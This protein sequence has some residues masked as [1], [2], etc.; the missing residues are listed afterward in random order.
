L[1]QHLVR[2][3]L[4]FVVLLALL[5][6]AARFYEIG[7]IH[8]LDAIFYDSKVR[9]TM[10]QGVDERVVILDIDEKS[11]GEIGR[12][13]WGRDRLAQL[14]GKLFDR[15]GIVLLGFD[16]VFAEP[17]ESSGLK[18][19]EEL[20]RKELKDNAAFRTLLQSLRPQL[21]RDRQFAEAL[22]GR[23][24]VLGY[25]LSARSDGVSSGALPPPALPAGSFAGRN[26][27]FTV[28]NSH[29]GNLVEFQN[30]AV[31][32][33]HFNPLVDFDGISR[34]VPLLAEYK[35]EYYE[36]L[37]LAMLRVLLGQPK[38]VP[39][40]PE[41]K[42]FAAKGY[43]GMEAIDLPT[44]RG[45]LRIPV[46]ENAAALIPYRGY[47]GSFRYFSVADILADRIEPSQLK[48]KI[49]LVG[50]TAPGLLDLRA[51]PVGEAYPGV[52]I[53][54]NLI[55]GMLDGTI[56]HKPSYVLGAEVILLLL[57]GL[58]M[59]F[60]LPL[61][62]PLRASLA[63]LLL[64]LFV[65]TVNL[66]FWQYGHLVLPLGASVLLILVLF[67]LNMS[68]GYFVESR[69]KRQFTE[70]FG[71][72]V[73]PELV[74]EMSRD[75]ESY[76]ME[77]R[78]AELTVLFSDVR[79]FTTISE[80]LGAEELTRLMNEYLSA[81]TE[82]VRANRGT[83]DKYIGDAIMAFWGA[84][85][86]DPQHARHAVVAAMQMQAALPAINERFAARGWPEIKIGVGINTGEMT[87]GDMGSTVRK[88]YTVMGDAVNLASRLE[89]ITKQ[90]GVG[91]LVG[92]GTRKACA[93]IVFRE[94]DRVQ[95]KGKE[96]PVAI[97]EPVGVE[98]EVDKAVQDELKLWH[99][100]L[101]YY[102]A[103]DWDQTEVAL[104][105]LSRMA[106]ERTL[107]TKYMERVAY[108]RKQPPGPDWNGVWKFETK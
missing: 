88:A 65:L 63:S 76:T 56:K 10:P 91:I 89:G 103:Q 98:G 107:Y 84:P 83:L 13:P 2:Y 90:Y 17:D 6:H 12:W 68:Y 5:G 77:G 54:A 19:L 1:R 47:Q 11:L 41:D 34:R 70:L 30:A 53:H 64:L 31:S 58:A 50:T 40:F 36:A 24:V 49:A 4:G 20:S 39:W 80:G 16:I 42:W 22:A 73:P 97:Y 14:V 82:V 78:K 62:S 93:G 75:P 23:P 66:A 28:W 25:Y 37:S 69:T 51:T 15:Y 79:G 87:V 27:P 26:I 96:E 85:V 45:T 74:E 99:Q 104:L 43:P 61:L 59:I 3:A 46:D 21:D 60:L 101:R 33:G 108:L 35:G 7:F 38:V 106:P 8:R 94:V 71:Q 100:A 32:G 48:G 9:L 44:S 86:S 72:Y 102:R 67:A 105:N 55:T 18:V 81:M 57:A 95:V 92:E 52:E 29:G